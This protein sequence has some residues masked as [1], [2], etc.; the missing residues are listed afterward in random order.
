MLKTTYVNEVRSVQMPAD[1]TLDQIAS[2]LKYDV[3][4]LLSYNEVAISSNSII[5]KGNIIS[6]E[7]K[8]KDYHGSHKY[9]IVSVGE[10]LESISNLYGI[11]AR[12]LYLLNKIP[13]SCQPIIGEKIFLKEKV[14]NS[15]KPKYKRKLDSN[16]EYLF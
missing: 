10:S 11:K 7:E 12:S 8:R 5:K 1:L 9:H 14:N 13:H 15:N 6:L 4:N 2:I 16:Q 3:V